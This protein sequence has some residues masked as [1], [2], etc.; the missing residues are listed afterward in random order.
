MTTITQKFRL[1][2]AGYYFFGLV[3]LV[4]LGFWKSYFSRFFNGTLDYAFYFH[5]HAAVM[6]LWIAAL[7]IQPILIRQK[8]LGIHRLTGRLT[9]IVMPIL[10]FSIILL[11]HYQIQK[12]VEVVDGEKL[13]GPHLMIPFKDLLILGIAYSIAV[14]Y[15]NDIHIHARAMIATGIVFI[16]PAMMRFLR[17]WMADRTTAFLCT[18]AFVYSILVVLLILERNQTRAR[19]VFPLILGL[20]VI[21]HSLILFQIKIGVWEAFAKW[22]AALPLT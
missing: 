14:F 15:R 18:M 6:L 5:F 8:K 22:F 10:F 4:L 16:E 20:F 17:L 12:H 7:I 3:V 9:Y 2:N 11:A 13:Y 1:E 21:V 19:W